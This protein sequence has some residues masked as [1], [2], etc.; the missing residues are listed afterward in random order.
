MNY[1]FFF[2]FHFFKT[3][4]FRYFSFWAK[5]PQNYKSS[6][7]T[8]QHHHIVLLY[9]TFHPRKFTFWCWLFSL[10]FAMESPKCKVNKCDNKMSDKRH[11]K[12]WRHRYFFF[13]FFLFYNSCF[14][15]TIWVLKPS[16]L[17]W[18]CTDY[19]WWEGLVICCWWTLNLN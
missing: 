8:S 1:R 16:H 14:W 12:N 7:K 9:F 2:L 11:T 10:T 13:F 5:T 15:K 17:R 19:S 3:V 18:H 6:K 4:I